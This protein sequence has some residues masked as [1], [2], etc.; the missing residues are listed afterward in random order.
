MEVRG[1]GVIHLPQLC[2]D[3][4]FRAWT[5]QRNRYNFIMQAKLLPMQEGRTLHIKTCTGLWC[6]F[7]NEIKSSAC[8]KYCNAIE[9]SL[10]CSTVSEMTHSYNNTKC[11]VWA[12]SVSQVVFT[13]KNKNYQ[14]K[15]AW[16]LIYFWIIHYCKKSALGFLH[17][18]TRRITLQ[19]L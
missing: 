13:D 10:W 14:N 18:I 9:S 7:A 16:H 8:I 3:L 5:R 2:Y 19:Q 6:T 17:V 1:Q 4:L 15:S 11:I 12:L